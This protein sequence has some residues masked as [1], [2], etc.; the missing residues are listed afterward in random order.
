MKMRKH[1]PEQIGCQFRETDGRLAEN[2]GSKC[3]VSEC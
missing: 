2:T 3:L 1:T